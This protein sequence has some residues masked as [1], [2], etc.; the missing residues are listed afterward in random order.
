MK[1]KVKSR[2]DI[3]QIMRS[4]DDNSRL[5]YWFSSKMLNYA[6]RIIE[7]DVLQDFLYVNCDIT[8]PAEFIEEIDVS[9]KIEDRYKGKTFTLNDEEM[10][11]VRWAYEFFR[12]FYGD[13]EDLKAITEKEPEEDNS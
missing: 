7:V 3:M 9:C 2:E 12:D 5:R 4:S 10:Q 11:R 6:G 1:V 13:D 8:W